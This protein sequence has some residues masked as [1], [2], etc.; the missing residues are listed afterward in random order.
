MVVSF[1]TGN[2][3]YKLYGLTCILWCTKVCFSPGQLHGLLAY[4]VSNTSIVFTNK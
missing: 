3:R 4:P 2:G 1:G